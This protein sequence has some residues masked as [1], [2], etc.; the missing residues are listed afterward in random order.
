M[1]PKSFSGIC[2]TL[3]HAAA[4]GCAGISA[5]F[6]LTSS[7]EHVPSALVMLGAALAFEVIAAVVDNGTTA[8]T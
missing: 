4:L 2:C 1:L 6:F 7:I 5:Y 3:I 8:H